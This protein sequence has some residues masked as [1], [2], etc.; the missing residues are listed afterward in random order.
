MDILKDNFSII[1]F[2]VLFA[3]VV[4]VVFFKPMKQVE[5]QTSKLVGNTDVG[6]VY[7]DT[8]NIKVVKKDNQY[9][10]VVSAEEFYNNKDF[11]SSIRASDELKN[12]SSEMTIYMFTNDGKYYCM[13]ERYIIDNKG[14]IC[15]K[16]GADMK[17][18]MIDE[19]ILSKIYVTAL[20]SLNVRAQN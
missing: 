8:N 3:L 18:Q 10:L 7:I 13:P 5:A 17:L 1:G 20:Q 15:T 2:V 4:G 6:T 9:Y 19:P 11:L 12:A 14:N 16:L